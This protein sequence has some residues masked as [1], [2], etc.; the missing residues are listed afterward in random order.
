MPKVIL[1]GYILIPDSD[2][3]LVKEALISHIEHTRQETGCTLFNV[4]QDIEN[5]NRFNVYEEF[6]DQTAFESHQQRVSQSEWGK[7]T[8]N[9]ERFYTVR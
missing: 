3:E 2:L 7:V 9:V 1:E 6:T 5:P 8:V 4:K